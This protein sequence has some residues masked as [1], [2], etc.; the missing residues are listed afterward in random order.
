VYDSQL[1]TQRYTQNAISKKVI[2]FHKHVLEVQDLL[3][4]V[5]TLT[6]GH[7]TPGLQGAHN[8]P[9]SIVTGAVDIAATI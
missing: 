4:G 6:I 7:V 5:Q 2:K 9:L 1:L 3:A 8:H